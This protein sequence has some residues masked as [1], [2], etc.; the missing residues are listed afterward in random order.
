MGKQNILLF[1]LNK[2]IPEYGFLERYSLS[3]P[4]CVLDRSKKLN[5]SL[6][7]YGE[8]SHS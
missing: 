3:F 5:V 8:T 4:D 7:L 6:H 2:T 1:K